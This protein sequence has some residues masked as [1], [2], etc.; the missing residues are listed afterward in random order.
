[1]R[2]EAKVVVTE[3]HVAPFDNYYFTFK[4]EGK[5]HYPVWIGDDIKFAKGVILP[6]KLIEIE[7]DYARRGAYYI[8]KDAYFPVG[9]L[10]H[11]KEKLHKV[12]QWWKMRT[13]I[14]AYVWGIG[15]VF[16]GTVPQWKD[17]L[18]K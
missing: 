12:Y 16:P 14:T 13:I 3:H 6:W 15:R 18:R 2:I 1:M 7:R 17:L 11:L 8:R 4:W 5:R 9:F 10:I